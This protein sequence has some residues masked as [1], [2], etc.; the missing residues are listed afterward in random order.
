MRWLFLFG[1]WLI[2]FSFG[3]TIASMAPLVTPISADLSIGSAMMGAILGAWPLV[4]IAAAVPCGILLDRIGPGAGL[5]LAA[6]VMSLSAFARSWAD[7][8][9]QLMAAV[10]LFGI[11]G[12]LISIAFTA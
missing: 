1:V 3:V 2:Y 8:P 10:G 7:A 11:G 12:P 5:C 4:Y 6:A 9:W